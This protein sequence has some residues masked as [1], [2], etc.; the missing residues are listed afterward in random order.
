MARLV[1]GSTGSFERRARRVVTHSASRNPMATRVPYVGMKN[2]PMVISL[3]DILFLASGLLRHLRGGI[4]PL[5][6]VPH[7][8]QQQASTCRDSGIGDVEIRE[9]IGLA[10]VQLDEIRDR[11]VDDAI[12]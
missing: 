4:L 9:I 3:G 6:R 5:P 7:V 2:R 12:V 10:G 1:T 11:A 8:Q